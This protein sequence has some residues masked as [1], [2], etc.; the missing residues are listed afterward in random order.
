MKRINSI[1]LISIAMLVGATISTVAR[2]EDLDARL[3]A[4]KRENAA[5]KK[6]IR[7]EALENENAAL[8]K[9]L[10]SSGPAASN[11]PDFQPVKKRAELPIATSAFAYAPRTNLVKAPNRA[12]APESIYIAEVPQ[13]SGVYFGGAFGAAWTHSRVASAERYESYFPTN[14]PPVFGQEQNNI[15]FGRGYG[16]IS[17]IFLGVNGIF[18]SAFLLGGQLEGT[19]AE[20]SFNSSGTRAYTDFNSNGPTGRTAIGDFRP[21]VHSRWMASALMRAGVLLDPATLLYA[22]GGWVDGKFDYQDLVNNTFFEPNEYFWANGVTAGGGLERRIGSN[23]A[24]RAE[25]RYTQFRNVD[26]G[27]N[28][29]FVDS[30]GARQTNVVRTSFENSMHVARIG[31]SYLIQP[32]WQW[33]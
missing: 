12:S 31:F 25:Y 8:K 20:V 17:D 2:A 28:F 32:S 4:L 26:V 10:S 1:A 15:G 27:N 22:I 9:Q 19:I 11:Q 21:H 13:W 14:S 24:L 5:L 23:W 18:G 7:I 33:D 6:R 16:A 30:Q 29:T 3:E